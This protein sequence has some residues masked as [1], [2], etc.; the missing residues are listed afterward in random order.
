MITRFLFLAIAFLL[1]P[2][3]R[4]YSSEPDETLLR[5]SGISII[6]YPQSVIFRGTDFILSGSVKIHLDKG[7]SPEDIFTANELIRQLR[8]QWR[9]ICNIT[10]NSK[11][12]SIF[13]T[14]KKTLR[15]LGDQGYQLDISSGRV[16]V[17]ANEATGLFYGMQSLLQLIQKE[18][19]RLYIRGMIINDWPDISIRAVHYDTKHFQEKKN[20]VF[21]F[22]RVLASYKINMLI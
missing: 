6:P 3:K 1:F 8:D 22:I 13:L 11:E 12:S 14:R 21:N 15:Q 7:A 10:E 17:S 16:I 19:S 18:N 5:K 4:G 2:A 9:I 20:Y